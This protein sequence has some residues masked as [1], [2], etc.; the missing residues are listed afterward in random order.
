MQN[1]FSGLPGLSSPS[2]AQSNEKSVIP[3]RIGFAP[4]QK[5]LMDEQAGLSARRKF[6]PV[7]LR[8]VNSTPLQ[9]RE[10]SSFRNI[11]QNN[12]AQNA[13]RM[14]KAQRKMA[15]LTSLTLLKAQSQSASYFKQEAMKMEGVKLE[16]TVPSLKINPTDSLSLFTLLKGYSQPVNARRKTNVLIQRPLSLQTAVPFKG[17][18][19]SPLGIASNPYKKLHLG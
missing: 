1:L 17:A 6:K 10:N 15:R 19:F 16:G 8:R 5:K 7:P 13:P 18:G 4:M 12:G 11:S 9:K 2:A 3:I 14:T